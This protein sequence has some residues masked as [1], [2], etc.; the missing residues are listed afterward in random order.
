M[1][2]KGNKGGKKDVNYQRELNIEN[3]IEL[4]TKEKVKVKTYYLME[5]MDLVAKEGA[6]ITARQN[7]SSSCS[8][9]KRN[10]EV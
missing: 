4:V 7:R 9:D 5:N 2:A 1:P 3:L 8:N 6:Y 10:E